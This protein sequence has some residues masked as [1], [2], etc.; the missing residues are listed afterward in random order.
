VGVRIPLVGP[1]GQGRAAASNAR[2]AVNLYPETDDAGS[3][4]K[5]IWVGTPG[6]KLWTTIAA[7]C[8]GWL[9]FGSTL[10]FVAGDK[11][12]SCDTS[13]TVSAALGTLQT[14]SGHVSMTRNR[15]QVAIADNTQRWYVYETLTGDFF[16]L[17]KFSL[18]TAITSM[19]RA[20][21][22]L[23]VTATAHGGT[24][25][26]YARIWGATNANYNLLNAQITV[27]DPNTFTV[28]V[29]NAGTSPDG[30]LNAKVAIRHSSLTIQPQFVAHMDGY[31][32]LSNT[33]T[34]TTDGVHSGQWYLTEADDFSTL[35]A[36]KVAVAQRNPDA[37]LVPYPLGG[38][39]HLLGEESGEVWWDN[40]SNSV[41]PF[42]PITTA[43]IPWG[44]LAPWSVAELGEGLAWLG[45]KASGSPTVFLLE[46][47]YKPT[48]IASH[49][50]TYRLST[51]STSDLAA[52]TAYSYRDLGH[53]FYVL[54]IGSETWV[55]D[56]VESEASGMKLWHERT[57]YNGS[58][59]AQHR[60]KWHVYFAGKHLLT[61]H[62]HAKILELDPS[63]YTDL[64]NTTTRQIQRQGV[65]GY[66]HADDGPTIHKRV[67]VDMEPVSSAGTLLLES[68]DNKGR[69]WTSHGEV[70]L[71][72][73][74]DDGF[75][76]AEWF[77]LGYVD[78]DRLYRVTTTAAVSVVFVG[79][80]A[81][82][83]KAGG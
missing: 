5:L 59:Y 53:E 38:H 22:T 74:T 45:K 65:S 66:V 39:L 63:T 30:S 16:T 27:V 11:L 25:G 72:L 76:R 31:G 34:S 18:V 58:T 32:I 62:T 77:A 9:V 79:M 78:K 14:S 55:Y 37:M 43:A 2:R 52:A 54:T 28:T 70:S 8:R 1:S 49:A 47:G 67:F 3:K 82:V 13:G 15:T 10:Y 36:S 21:T 33:R 81:D 71:V 44:C 69:T 56:K 17:D 42:E 35:R 60:G 41:F 83:E 64:D 61:D 6:T 12:Y 68:S 51:Y 7:V 80:Y 26:D 40:P 29:T 57:S 75:S 20:G 73:T 23:T 50:L 46:G 48:E 24:T 19:T 4:E